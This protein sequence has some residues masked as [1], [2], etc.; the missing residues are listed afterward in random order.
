[1]SVLLDSVILID[2]L[3]GNPA[4]TA[5]LRSLKDAHSSVVTRAEVL[6]GLEP[7]FRKLG[8]RLL[9]R[10]P[11]LPVDAEI[12]DLAADLRRMNKWKLPDAFQA[13][14]AQQHGLKL[15]TRNTRDFPPGKH[16]F[17]VVPY[18]LPGV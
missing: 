5:Y 8:R 9:D 15:A 2:H 4:A 18:K 1:M 13:A 7:Q 14:L 11:T 3:N 17:V 6:A 16:S 12:A 10:Y